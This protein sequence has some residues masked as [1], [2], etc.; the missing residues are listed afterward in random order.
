MCAFQMNLWI[1]RILCVW[2]C[3]SKVSQQY[4]IKF[5]DTAHR[6]YLCPDLCHQNWIVCVFVV[7]VFFLLNLVAAFSIFSMLDANEMG[8]RRCFSE[9]YIIH[10][11]ECEPKI[12]LLHAHCLNFVPLFFLRI[13]CA[14]FMLLLYSPSSPL[15]IHTHGDSCR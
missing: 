1:K 11:F 13:P 5:D 8:C 14:S 3:V 9:I 15:Y 12:S 6:N 7:V 10:H 2:L 4:T